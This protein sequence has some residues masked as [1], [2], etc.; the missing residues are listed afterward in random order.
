MVREERVNLYE[1]I[2]LWIPIYGHG[3]H[4][5]YPQSS[6]YFAEKFPAQQLPCP[7]LMHLFNKSRPPQSKIRQHGQQSEKV[8]IARHE[9]RSGSNQK[10]VESRTTPSDGLN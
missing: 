1:A 9:H 3:L 4:S 2:L 6:S 8:R 7:S 10:E 5:G